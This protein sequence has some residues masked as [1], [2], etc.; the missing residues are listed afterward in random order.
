M[1]RHW[2]RLVCL[3]P[4]PAVQIFAV[5]VFVG[6]LG[7]AMATLLVTRGPFPTEVIGSPVSPDHSLSTHQRGAGLYR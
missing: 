2:L 4:R 6:L 3:N 7:L 1:N 5:F